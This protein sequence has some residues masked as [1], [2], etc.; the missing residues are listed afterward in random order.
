M[1]VT[2]EVT[3]GDIDEGTPR[4]CNTCPV[5]RAMNRKLKM[6]LRAFADGDYT[7]GI[8]TMGSDVQTVEPLHS[9]PLP[10]IACTFVEVFDFCGSTEV[11]PIVF[12]VDIPE[13]YVRAS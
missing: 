12:T 1:E 6:P 10:S 9:G 3:Q 13:Q 4:Q 8:Y 11:H 2:I 7:Y 5:A